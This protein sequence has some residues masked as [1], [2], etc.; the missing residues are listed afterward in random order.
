LNFTPPL[1]LIFTCAG[2]GQIDRGQCE[3]RTIL[4]L[5]T[6]RISTAKGPRSYVTLLFLFYCTI[7]GI[8]QK[9]IIELSNTLSKTDSQNT[10]QG[11]L[12]FSDLLKLKLFSE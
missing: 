2:Y 5:F 7:S 6:G 4:A 8:N 3:V 10:A 9:S 12:I 11:K 1:P